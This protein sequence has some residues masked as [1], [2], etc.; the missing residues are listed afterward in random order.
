LYLDW[1]LLDLLDLE[2][3]DDP[4]GEVADEEES[5][6][7]T[8]RLRPVLHRSILRMLNLNFKGGTNKKVGRGAG[9]WQMLGIGIGP[10]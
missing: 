9:R 6:H 5:Y 2:G 1:R 4:D 3:V 8:T 7:L 10:W